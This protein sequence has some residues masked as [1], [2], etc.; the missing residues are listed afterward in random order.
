MTTVTLGR[1]AI[2]VTDPP[3]SL[4]NTLTYWKREL[5][6]DEVRHIRAVK[7]HY[8]DLYSI[9]GNTLTTLPGFG[10]KILEHF[11]KTGIKYS[12]VDKRIPLPEPDIEKACQGLRNHQFE[13]VIQM[14]LSGGGILSSSTGTGKTVMAASIIKA[15]NPDD[16]KMRGTPLTVFAAPDKDINRKNWEELRVLLPDR[17]VGLVMSGVKNFS[18]DVQVITLDSLHLLDPEDIGILIVD[19]VHSSASET[20]VETISK[21]ANAARWGVSATPSGRFD[22]GDMLIEGLFGP[23]V[24]QL[25][26]QDAVRLGALVPI[27]VYWVKAP[28]PSVGMSYYLKYKNRDSKIR[29][30]I[31]NNPPYS[32][33]VAQL[34][35]KIP[36]SKSVLCFTQWIAQ[37]ANIHAH[38]P[39]VEYVHA[40][41]K[42]GVGTICPITPKHRKELYDRMA[43]GEIRKMLAT[44]CWKQGVNFKALD[45]VVN[46]S[47]GSSDIAAKQIPGRAS[48]RADGKDKAYVVDFIHE[49]DVNEDGKPG[50]LLA[51]DMSRKR[52]YRDLG[53]KQ[54]TVDSINELPFIKEDTI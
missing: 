54:Y 17:E 50:P 35:N 36:E 24:Y 51:S 47:G 21:I 25:T 38:C 39:N 1:G 34:L 13:P 23:V 46:A 27:E 40:Q 48:R 19:E 10:H 22:G 49:W 18:E 14:L 26:Y 37:M 44:H 9:D 8:E 16:L 31:I 43:S 53:F 6:F 2:T 28:S 33:L 15:F 5:M 45:I 4:K 29:A 41:T 3:P 30:A 7:G 11:R 32:K 20:R 52:S 42:D 12:I